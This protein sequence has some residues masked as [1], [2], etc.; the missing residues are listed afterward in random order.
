MTADQDR[1]AA[2][3][4]KV[5]TIRLALMLTELRL[6][7]I[8]QL[9]QDFAARADAEGVPVARFLATRRAPSADPMV[10]WVTGV[11]PIWMATASGIGCVASPE[12]HRNFEGRTLVRDDLSNVRP[13]EPERLTRV[14]AAPGIIRR[15]VEWWNRWFARPRGRCGPGRPRAGASVG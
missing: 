12:S 15:A 5:D 1:P 11:S 4:N 13:V 3:P 10:R 14:A 9:W 6:P 7:T 2:D 8:K